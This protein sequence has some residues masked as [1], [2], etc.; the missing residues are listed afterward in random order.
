MTRA[1]EIKERLLGGPSWE[2]SV[3]A[4]RLS[5]WR[6]Y[7]LGHKWSEEKDESEL[8]VVISSW[9]ECERK[10][11]GQFRETYHWTENRH[12]PVTRGEKPDG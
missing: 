9:V 5:I 12:E 11:C 8:G 6:C 10:N 1:Q 3:W 4:Y 7:L 2:E